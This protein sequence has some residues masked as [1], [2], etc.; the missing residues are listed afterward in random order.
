ML[1]MNF[2]IDE[3]VK[4]CSVTS[5]AD[6]AGLA[7]GIKTNE[8]TEHVKEDLEGLTKWER[9]NNVSFNMDKFF[10]LK[11]NKKE[12]FSSPYEIRGTIIS[13]EQRTRD[14]G[15]IVNNKGTPEDH[16]EEVVRQ[17]G[18]ISGMILRTFKTREKQCM[19]TLLKT[20]I[21]S[22][23]DFCSV[24]WAPY[25]VCD[26]RKVEKIQA[27][28]TRWIEKPGSDTD[29]D[30]WDRLKEFNLYSV[31][32]RFERYRIIYMSKILHA[33]VVNPGIEFNDNKGS[34]I[35]LTSKIPKHTIKL[36][37]ESFM[38][39]GPRLF[40]QLS[41]FLKEF[42]CIDIDNFKKSVD[43]F[44]KELDLY[45]AKI[46]DQPNLSGSYTQRMDAITV[47]GEKTNSILRIK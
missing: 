34:R 18:R 14:L 38:V 6:D 4:Y 5:F 23:I 21:L 12:E 30:Y 31:Q 29:L 16:I 27:N 9:K 8:D 37:E 22:K 44:K 43:A 20:L 17:C 32:R 42:P 39:K 13:E 41:K 7:K 3:N 36:R 45:L 2:D 19:L 33:I 40:N 46:P 35:G 26:M 11:Y 15:V 25:K 28:F 47:L 1:I 10:N 24:L